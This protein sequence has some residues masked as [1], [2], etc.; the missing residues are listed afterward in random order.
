[1]EEPG[2]H[3]F[4]EEDLIQLSLL[5]GQEIDSL[6]DQNLLPEESRFTD[7]VLQTL[8]FPH[9]EIIIKLYTGDHYPAE[10]L[11]CEFEN[12]SLPR[13][14]IDELRIAIRKIMVQ[15]TE[16]NN[17]GC[18]KAREEDGEDVFGAFVFEM[19]AV[20]VARRTV[21][22][23]AAYREK[24]KRK[25]EEGNVVETKAILRWVIFY[26]LWFLDG[27]TDAIPIQ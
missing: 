24:N 22:F 15:D 13:L 5:R 7:E 25:I 2:H 19:S 12:V 26:L 21:E 1:M 10:Q 8:I 16:R 20:H 23:L 18:W 27:P 9:P 6:V 3:E 4:S 14:V 11:T 17:Y